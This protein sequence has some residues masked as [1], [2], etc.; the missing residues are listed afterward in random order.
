MT[1]HMHGA[2]PPRLS[3]LDAYFLDVE[4]GGP[5]MNIGGLLVL[6]R[7]EGRPPLTIDALRARVLQRL[8]LLPRLRARVTAV[9]L[10]LAQPVWADDPH[11]DVDRHVRA[12]PLTGPD[13]AAVPWSRILRAVE[14]THHE[15]MDRAHPLW[16]I[17]LLPGATRQQQV[18]HV[19]FHHA[20]VDGMRAMATAV[21][22]FDR[23]EDEAP[24]APVPALPVVD[25]SP[26]E[27]VTA[28]LAERGLRQLQRGLDIVLGALDPLAQLK[29]EQRTVETVLSFLGTPDPPRA[30]LNA[31]VGPERRYR[32]T[33]IPTS[34]ITQ[35]R[36]RRGVTAHDVVLGL[37]AGALARLFA[38]RGEPASWVRAL[39]PMARPLPADQEPLGNHASIC[40]V[41]LPVA[42]GPDD[43]RL[44]AV[45]AA[46]NA[47]K[48]SPQLRSGAEFEGLTDE[49]PPLAAAWMAQALADDVHVNLVVTYLRWSRRIPP[50]L[51]AQ[52]LVTYPLLPLAR[53]IGL[54][55][56]AVEAGGQ[57]GF[58]VTTDPSILPEPAFLAEALRAT[59]TALLR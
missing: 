57:V 15:P 52:H 8:A 30:S 58:A 43:D 19:R 37:V 31:L 28:V 55:I 16:D 44:R 22:L 59:A 13:G 1:A 27:M 12:S 26:T 51:G 6:E 49:A 34:E 21:A 9:P 53:R 4:P 23:P 24:V 11:F 41:D 56:G 10:R 20:L 54:F 29:R 47:A 45:A 7:P 14:T 35:I 50:L 42:P 46:A 17:T 36:R 3:P 38:A 40:F 48:H 25:P 5:A 33:V 32:T 18:L 2:L 39:V